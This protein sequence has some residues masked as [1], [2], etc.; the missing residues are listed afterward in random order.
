MKHRNGD[1]NL[2]FPRHIGDP[3]FVNDLTYDEIKA[4]V[5]E[6]AAVN[7]RLERGAQP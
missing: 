5:Q 2:P 7:E 1:Q 6:L 3:I 4:G